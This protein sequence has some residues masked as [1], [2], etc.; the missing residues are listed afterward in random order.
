MLKS[1]KLE[2]LSTSGE[3]SDPGLVGMQPQPESVQD[4]CCQLAGLLGLFTGGAEDHQVIC[5]LHQLPQPPATALP[6]LIEHVQSDV[7]QQ[8]ADR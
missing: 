5:V 4:R 6:R 2:A 8:R 3:V 7:G 1:Q